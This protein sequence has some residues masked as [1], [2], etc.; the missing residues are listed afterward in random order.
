MKKVYIIMTF[1]KKKKIVK[2]K[3]NTEVKNVNSKIIL[4]TIH[5]N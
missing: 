5:E 4:P 2:N 1:Q 3:I